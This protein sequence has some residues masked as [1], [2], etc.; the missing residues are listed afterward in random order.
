MVLLQWILHTAG[1]CGRMSHFSNRGTSQ[2]GPQDD[3]YRDELDTKVE[4]STPGIAVIRDGV[5]LLI[6]VVAS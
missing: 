2:I 1:G 3:S 6:E 4:A 5:P